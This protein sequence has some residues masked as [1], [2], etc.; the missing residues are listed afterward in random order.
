[1]TA[2]RYTARPAAPDVH[3]LGEGPVWDPARQR[4]LWVDI[5]AHAVHEGRL[6]PDGGTVTRTATTTFPTTV[7][8]VAVAASGDLLVA[9]RQVLTRVAPDGSRSFVARILPQERASRL[10]DG[11]VDPAGRFLIGSL[12]QDRLRGG[13]I[14]A[15]LDRDGVTVLDDDLDLSNGLA[16]SPAGDRL[17]S[18]DTIPGLI[19]ARDYDPATGAVGERRDWLQIG[20]GHPDGMCA[21][22]EGNL[23]IAVWGGSRVECRSPAG[24]LLAVVEVDAPQTSSC[25]F[26]GPDLDVLVITTAARDLSPADLAR[27]PG[28]GRLFTARVGV[29]GRPTAYWDPA[30]APSS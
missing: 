19:R 7:G 12:A 16:W 17:Y 25:A 18:V 27:H 9:E 15:R 26:A 30:C 11:A 6:D 29:A 14:L 1:M 20:D 13:E 23:W 21:D 5:V 24:E 4:L 3:A 8:A 10:N 22:A 28:S 2:P